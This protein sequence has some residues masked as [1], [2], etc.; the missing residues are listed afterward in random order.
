MKPPFAGEL[1]EKKLGRGPVKTRQDTWEKRTHKRK[2]LGQSPRGAGRENVKGGGSGFAKQ[3]GGGGGESKMFQKKVSSLGRTLITAQGGTPT[4]K[5]ECSTETRK[6]IT[7]KERPRSFCRR[8]EFKKQERENET[9]PGCGDSGGETSP[10]Q[11]T[12]KGDSSGKKVQLTGSRDKI[13]SR[14]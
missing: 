11:R 2:E 9:T 13:L 14:P 6:H 8:G 5:K 10:G 12:K 7:K 1:G 4:M 3:N